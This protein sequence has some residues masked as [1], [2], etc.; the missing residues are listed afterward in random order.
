MS[1]ASVISAEI[2]AQASVAIAT[3][4]DKGYLIGGQ[5]A[6]YKIRVSQFPERSL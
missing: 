4:I 6:K 2:A 3:D 1:S 5:I